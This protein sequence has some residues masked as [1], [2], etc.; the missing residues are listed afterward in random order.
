MLLA[1]PPCYPPCTQRAGDKK[2]LPLKQSHELNFL[3][4]TQ[5]LISRGGQKQPDRLQRG[6][7]QPSSL[8]A[9]PKATPEGSAAVAGSGQLTPGTATYAR[10]QMLGSSPSG[11]VSTPGQALRPSPSASLSTSTGTRA[12]P[13]FRDLSGRPAGLGTPDG[14]TPASRTP[15]SRRGNAAR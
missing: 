9:T 1:A 6:R 2:V 11:N 3:A 15:G 4:A 5:P 7:T 10:G 12:R 13:S 14:R 8:W